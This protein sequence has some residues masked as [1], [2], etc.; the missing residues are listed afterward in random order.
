MLTKIFL[1]LPHRFEDK[2]FVELDAAGRPTIPLCFSCA[3]KAGSLRPDCAAKGIEG[4][5]ILIVRF[6][7]GEGCAE[8][9][10][11]KADMLFVLGREQEDEP[12]SFMPSSDVLDRCCYGMRVVVPHALLTEAEYAAVFEASPAAIKM[13]PISLPAMGPGVAG[14]YYPMEL[15]GLPQEVQLTC[16]RMEMFYSVSTE[17]VETYLSQLR[18]LHPDQGNR[19]FQYLSQAA[20]QRRPDKARPQ[21]Q[22]WTIDKIQEEHQKAEAAAETSA[23]AAEAS[24]AADPNSAEAS[25]ETKARTFA[26]GIV[27]HQPKAAAK[28]KAKAKGMAKAPAPA[29]VLSS[30]PAPKASPTSTTSLAP[31][32]TPSVG[33]SGV[34]SML[35]AGI[36]CRGC[37]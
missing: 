3:D 24:A 32:P 10:T 1:F 26:F 21:A 4:L 20:V 37:G 22:Q 5:K 14:N 31:Q 29:P 2:T 12:Q 16:R 13:K 36:R 15:F 25:T 8:D 33:P 19:V 23:A 28:G 9:P 27:A 11:F 18:Q 35:D 30:V 17:H 34:S 6:R 7:A